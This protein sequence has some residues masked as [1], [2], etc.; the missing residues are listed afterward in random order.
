MS[1]T[2]QTAFRWVDIRQSKFLFQSAPALPRL[3]LFWPFLFS[4]ILLQVT[5][6]SC[7][8]YWFCWGES[9]EEEEE[10]RGEW[11]DRGREGRPRRVFQHFHPFLPPLPGFKKKTQK[12]GPKAQTDALN[13]GFDSLKPSVRASKVTKSEKT[14]C[15]HFSFRAQHITFVQGSDS[16]LYFQQSSCPTMGHI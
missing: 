4:G 13:D 5:G 3:T 2:V 11:G 16:A 7:H 8:C 1:E 14:W 12:F 10:K 9:R 15:Q 6:V